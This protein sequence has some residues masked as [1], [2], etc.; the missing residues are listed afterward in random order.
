MKKYNLCVKPAVATEDQLV[1]SSM[2]VNYQGVEAGTE[3][4]ARKYALESFKNIFGCPGV[5][6]VCLHVFDEGVELQP[7]SL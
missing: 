4:E 2:G 1:L 3:E 6:V 7:C 5:V